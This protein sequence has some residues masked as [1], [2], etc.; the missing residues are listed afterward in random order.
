MI[1]KTQRLRTLENEIRNNYETFVST[2]YALKEIKDDELYRE[3][4]YDT[5]DAFLKQRVPETPNQPTK[6]YKMAK[7][8][9][10]IIITNL[11][12]SPIILLSVLGNKG[13]FAALEK[14]IEV[15]SKH[16]KRACPCLV[17]SPV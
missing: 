16:E 13:V 1:T 11:I 12:K 10:I 4:G 15:E 14:T 8:P 17:L 5:W 9:H 2:S 3:G 7:P 6:I